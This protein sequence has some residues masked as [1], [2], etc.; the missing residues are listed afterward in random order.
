MAKNVWFTIYK[1]DDDTV[2]A[3]GDKQTCAKMM[4]TTLAGLN[5]VIH[6]VKVGKLR[7]YTIV[8]EDLDS[9]TYTVYGGENR[10]RPYKYK[11][12]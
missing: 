4:E 6:K 3:F 2:L 7:C 12:K 8:I 10:G 9:G 11:R 1:A 5:W